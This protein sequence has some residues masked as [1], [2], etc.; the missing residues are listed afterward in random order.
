M[1]A[2]DHK[3]R[4]CIQRSALFPGRADRRSRGVGGAK[5]TNAEEVKHGEGRRSP[6]LLGYLG[7]SPRI[8]FKYQLLNVVFSAYLQTENNGLTYSVGKAFD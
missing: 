1:A 7:L 6:V 2:L 4:Q 3:T 5:H 8:K